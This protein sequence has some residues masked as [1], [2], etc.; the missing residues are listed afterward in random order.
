LAPGTGPFDYL[1]VVP[2]DSPLFPLDLLQRLAQA[3]GTSGA[4]IA[5][6]AIPEPDR[7]GTPV[8]RPQPVFCLLRTR[9]LDSLQTFMAEGGRKIDAWTATHSTVE[10]AFNTPRDNPQHFFNANT[11]AQLQQLEQSSTH[12]KYVQTK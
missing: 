11:L 8:I 2:C 4:D 5:I 7:H 12:S 3:L 9:L 10:V 1:L 6:A